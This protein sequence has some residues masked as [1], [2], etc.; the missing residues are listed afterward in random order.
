VVQYVLD[1]NGD[2]VGLIE[3][4]SKGKFLDCDTRISTAILNIFAA[5]GTLLWSEEWGDGEPST[6]LKV[7]LDDELPPFPDE[8]E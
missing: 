1:G 6:R 7:N 4:H 8:V 5:D 3:A 2:K